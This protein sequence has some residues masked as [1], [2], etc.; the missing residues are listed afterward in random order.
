M[1]LAIGKAGLRQRAALP[2]VLSLSK[3]QPERVLLSRHGALRYL[4]ANG[5]QAAHFGHGVAH[6]D[7]RVLQAFEPY[8]F[9]PEHAPPPRSD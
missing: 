7:V 9:T 1:T 6:S 5:F 2:S 4:R 3:S 8:G